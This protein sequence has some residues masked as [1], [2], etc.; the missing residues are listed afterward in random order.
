MLEI[1]HK[2]TWA[3]LGRNFFSVLDEFFTG[4]V[5]IIS[6]RVQTSIWVWFA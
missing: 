2:P 6:S 1:S 3:Y 4:L 5:N